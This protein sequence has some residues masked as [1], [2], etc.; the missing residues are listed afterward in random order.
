M[1][2][3]SLTI[4]AAF[5]ILLASTTL[6]AD[7]LDQRIEQVGQKID[8][9][10]DMFRSAMKGHLPSLQAINALRAQI[11]LAQELYEAARSEAE[12]GKEF[13]AGAKLDAAE[14]LAEQVFETS[15]H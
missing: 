3:T 12:D 4:A 14:Y 9:A 13:Q 8:E 5:A 1:R 10:D 7:T 11:I 15:K 2:G 6:L